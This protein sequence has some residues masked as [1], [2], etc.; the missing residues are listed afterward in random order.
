[1]IR[2]LNEDLWKNP[3]N[4][5]LEQFIAAFRKVLIPIMADVRKYGLR[6]RN[7]QKHRRVVDRYYNFAVDGCISEDEIVQR[8]QKRFIRY[9]DSLFRFFRVGWDPVE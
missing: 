3:F 2:D 6:K 8:Y 7:L 5:E 4:G 1:M 9:R